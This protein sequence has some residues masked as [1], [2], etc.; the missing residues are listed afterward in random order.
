MYI[1]DHSQWFFN[2]QS[3][4]WM[5]TIFFYYTNYITK[6]LLNM[7]KLLISNRW[8]IYYTRWTFFIIFNVISI[9]YLLKNTVFNVIKKQKCWLRTYS[10]TF[11]QN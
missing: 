8:S 1:I 6:D 2:I 10:N 5:Y 11:M 4:L 9:K 7:N 3:E